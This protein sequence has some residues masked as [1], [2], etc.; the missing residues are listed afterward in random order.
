MRGIVKGF[1]VG[2]LG[3]IQ[4]GEL[5]MRKSIV[6]TIALTTVAFVAGEASA[7]KLTEQQVTSV[8]AGQKIQES[9]LAWGCTKKCGDKTC[10]YSCKK[11]KN[12]KSFDCQGVAVIVRSPSTLPQLTPSVPKSRVTPP[13][14]GALQK[15]P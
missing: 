8:C 2:T 14:G 6:F 10:D 3:L 13:A 1:V 11:D 15:S 12:G 7:T 9:S 5:R 4:K